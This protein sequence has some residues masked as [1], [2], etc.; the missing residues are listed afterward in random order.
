MNDQDTYGVEPIEEEP[1][2]P[3]PFVGGFERVTNLRSGD[4]VTALYVFALVR[5]NQKAYVG[6]FFGAFPSFAMAAFRE[7]LSV[8]RDKGAFVPER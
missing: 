5:K 4:C 7:W 1:V 8:H 6:T 2:L 3:W